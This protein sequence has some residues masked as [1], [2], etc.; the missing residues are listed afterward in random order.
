MAVSG[1]SIKQRYYLY[2]VSQR[3]WMI[4]ERA[5]NTC[6]LL[7]KKS[8]DLLSIQDWPCWF[9]VNECWNIDAL[10]CV[11]PD[12]DHKRTT[13]YK[14]RDVFPWFATAAHT[15]KATVYWWKE[16]STARL[17]CHIQCIISVWRWKGRV[18]CWEY[19]R[20][21]L[22]VAIIWTG[23]GIWSVHSCVADQWCWQRREGVKASCKRSGY[24]VQLSLLFYH[25]SA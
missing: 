5:N 25:Q 20:D 22:C 1:N 10:L 24:K 12:H 13:Y 21:T 7:M 14:C 9:A 17:L 8:W 19:Y 23:Y 4:N 18:C 6:M 15:V 3:W 11:I 16:V 2:R